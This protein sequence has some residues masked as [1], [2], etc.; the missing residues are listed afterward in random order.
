M[1]SPEEEADHELG[2][3]LREKLENYE[4]PVNE[5]VRLNVFAALDRSLNKWY[6]FAALG[7][8][9]IIAAFFLGERLKDRYTDQKG[10]LSTSGKTRIVI[11]RKDDAKSVIKDTHQNSD[12]TLSEA[13]SAAA[14]TSGISEKK[15]GIQ[16]QNSKKADSK[17]CRPLALVKP[18]I[19]RRYKLIPLQTFEDTVKKDIR[20]SDAEV[21]IEAGAKTIQLPVDLAFLPAIDQIAPGSSSKLPAIPNV[22]PDKGSKP[23]KRPGIMHGVTAIFSAAALQSFQLVDLGHSGSER[24]QNFQFAPLLSNR[25]LSYKLTAGVE[26]KHT[27]LLLSYQYLRSWNEYE[28]GTDQVIAAQNDMHQYSMIRLG[29]GH[30]ADDRSH[31]I[32]IGIR[33]RFMVPRQILATSSLHL[34][35]DYTRV[36]PIGQD[37]VWGNLGFYKRI[38][39]S[40]RNVLEAG[41]FVQYSFAK[42][43]VAGKSWKYRPYQFGVSLHFRIR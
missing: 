20:K 24:I 17:K 29:E 11:R 10:A 34:G 40:D 21:S 8:L 13:N 4:A 7:I 3:K 30:I 36:V 28:I 9:L 33:Q 1:K 14:T 15:A 19:S 32:G 35:V 43:N 5:Q 37:M 22:L 2:K 6:W 42:R 12:K 38:Y 18:Y 23:V 25:S 31:L 39:Q 41:P 16:K 27:Q 26:K